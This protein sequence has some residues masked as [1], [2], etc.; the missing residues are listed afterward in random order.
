M[1]I[2]SR[3]DEPAVDKGRGLT[4]VFGI[5]ANCHRALMG[6]AVADCPTGALSIED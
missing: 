1:T 6:Q 2:R 5:S 4:L 3:A